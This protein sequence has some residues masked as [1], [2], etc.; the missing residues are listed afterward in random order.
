VG[1]VGVAIALARGA[2]WPP[3]I[4]ADPS[5]QLGKRRRSDLRTVLEEAHPRL[6]LHTH[7]APS[8]SPS[9]TGPL[10]SMLSRTRVITAIAHQSTRWN[11]ASRQGLVSPPR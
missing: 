10:P 5:T 11:A 8:S 9:P 3:P 7:T 4:K 2:L 6:C 1:L